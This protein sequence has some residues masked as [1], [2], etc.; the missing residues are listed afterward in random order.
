[1]TSVCTPTNDGEWGVASGE[2]RV[3]EKRKQ[4][5]EHTE[6]LPLVLEK[7]IFPEKRTA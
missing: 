7:K 4:Q 1:M 5:N 3:K 2:W 6:F